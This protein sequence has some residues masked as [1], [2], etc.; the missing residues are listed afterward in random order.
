MNP[1]GL[2]VHVAPDILLT[3]LQACG[4]LSHGEAVAVGQH[5]RLDLLAARIAI[6]LPACDVSQ[7]E[8]DAVESVSGI[9]ASAV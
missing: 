9:V 8:V 2:E 7:Q 5:F 6:R 3:Q 1:R 4:E